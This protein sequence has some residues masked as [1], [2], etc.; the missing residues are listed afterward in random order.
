MTSL[1]DKNMFTYVII[2][3]KLYCGKENVILDF[4]VRFFSNKQLYIYDL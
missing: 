1:L 3:V 4:C 2:S